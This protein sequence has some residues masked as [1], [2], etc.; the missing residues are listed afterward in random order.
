MQI[1][2]MQTEADPQRVCAHLC[3]QFDRCKHRQLKP[4]VV[5]ICQSTGGGIAIKSCGHKEKNNRHTGLIESHQSSV[6][7]ETGTFL[8]KLVTEQLHIT[9]GWRLLNKMKT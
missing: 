8:I 6:T 1:C 7:L 3:R 9:R 4:G 5:C 2:L